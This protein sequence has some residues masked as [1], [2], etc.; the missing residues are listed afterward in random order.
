MRSCPEAALN[1]AR[2]SRFAP[3]KLEK[4]RRKSGYNIFFSRKL[5]IDTGIC[6]HTIHRAQLYPAL[7]RAKLPKHPTPRKGT[8]TR[9]NQRRSS[10]HTKHPTPR[11]GTNTVAIV[12]PPVPCLKQSTPR[13]GTNRSG[14]SRCRSHRRNNIPPA[15][16]RLRDMVW[17]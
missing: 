15:R 14:C 4:L 17:I 11:K 16:G 1:A 13:K 6:Y 12:S 8:N 7:L 9:P 5:A 3:K 10:L 2:F